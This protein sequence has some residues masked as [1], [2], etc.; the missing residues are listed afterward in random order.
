MKLEDN[1]FTSV[2]DTGFHPSIPGMGSTVST[3]GVTSDHDKLFVALNKEVD[4]LVNDLFSSIATVVKNQPKPPALPTPAAATTPPAKP[5]TG[6]WPGVRKVLHNIW[7]GNSPD[8]PNFKRESK[9]ESYNAVVGQLDQLYNLIEE[10]LTT[11]VVAAPNMSGAI[12]TPTYLQR[13][14][15]RLLLKFKNNL[16][17]VVSKYL[18]QAFKISDVDKPADKSVDKTPESEVQPTEPE[19]AA[20]EPE[21]D[22][23]QTATIKAPAKSKRSKK[24]VEDPVEE[25]PMEKDMKR[26]QELEAKMHSHEELSEDELDEFGALLLSTSGQ[27]FDDAGNLV[28]T[29]KNEEH[30]YARELVE[31]LSME[32]KTQFYKTL[33]KSGGDPNHVLRHIVDALP[34]K[35][36]VEYYKNKLKG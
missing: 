21:Q 19:K 1:N 4:K 32:S 28:S 15:G 12:A 6:I 31:S 11:S 18:T 17:H 14:L 29:G 34:L 23:P 13:E 3:T 33:L 24:K 20:N 5:Q 22:F 7:Y 2:V 9:L 27:K 16:R 8:N 35:E 30:M 10:N 25:T 26:L 36:R